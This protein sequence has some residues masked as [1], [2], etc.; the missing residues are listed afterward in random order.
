MLHTLRQVASELVDVH[1]SRDAASSVASHFLERAADTNVVQ[2]PFEHMVVDN[3]LQPEMYRL[4]EEQWPNDADFA[5]VRLPPHS[6]GND[7]YL[8]SRRAK[9]IDSFPRGVEEL[10]RLPDV[11]QLLSD[12]LRHPRFVLSLFERFESTLSGAMR[13]ISTKSTDKAGF[14]MYA[15]QDAGVGEA[16]GAHVDALRKLLTI[17]IYVDLKGPC[18]EKSDTAWGTT[19]YGNSHEEWRPLEFRP[20]IAT[21]ESIVV[22]FARNRAFI[23]PNQPLAQHGVVGGEAGVQRRTVMCGYWLFDPEV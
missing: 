16:L 18:S 15:C 2:Q 13:H 20:N 7:R 8:G 3:F 14:R 22:R 23:M 11:W 17:V 6:S 4:V 21:R 19:L 10:A 1:S 9:L 12:S 5:P